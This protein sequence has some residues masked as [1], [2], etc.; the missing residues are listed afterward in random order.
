MLIKE[1]ET[2]KKMKERGAQER[3]FSLKKNKYFS[4]QKVWSI[5]QA[6]E[7]AD[8]IESPKFVHQRDLKK[9]RHYGFAQTSGPG[10]LQ[11][12]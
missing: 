10:N 6:C 1:N 7:L 2:Q 4:N 8:V 12:N 5:F 11:A 9:G 3:Y